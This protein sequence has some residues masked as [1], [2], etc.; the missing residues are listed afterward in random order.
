MNNSLTSAEL[1]Q[2]PNPSHTRRPAAAARAWC[3]A[4]R[5]PQPAAL[6]RRSAVGG[7]PC[8]R[9]RRLPSPGRR[10]FPR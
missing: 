4:F 9:R 10:R 8:S 5:S 2:Q 7:Q 1:A 3:A 6:A